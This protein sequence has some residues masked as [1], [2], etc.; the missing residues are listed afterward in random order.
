MGTRGLITNLFWQISYLILYY[1]ELS[2]YAYHK[3]LSP[4]IFLTFR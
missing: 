1:K 2:D 3:G 4:P